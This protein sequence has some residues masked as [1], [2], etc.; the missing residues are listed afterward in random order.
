MDSTSL[1]RLDNDIQRLTL[2]EQIWL[3]ER[4]AHYIR[5]NAARQ[6][7]WVEGQLAAMA[8]DP[9]IRRE[10]DQI[11]AE[12]SDTELDGLTDTP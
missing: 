7:Q 11:Q 2:S 3:L 1:Q 5:T 4:L 9:D 6:Q 10:M 12:F 8:A